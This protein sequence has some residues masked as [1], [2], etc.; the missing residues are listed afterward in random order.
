MEVNEFSL[1]QNATIESLF[2]PAISS[3]SWVLSMQPPLS[4]YSELTPKV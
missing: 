4:P 2:S 1:G 3:D